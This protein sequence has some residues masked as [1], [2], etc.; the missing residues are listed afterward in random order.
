ML[1]FDKKNNY[2]K[3]IFNDLFRLFR[4]LF[5]LLLFFLVLTA[6]IY[7]FF[8]YQN[9]VKQQL[10]VSSITQN[11]I[12]ELINKLNSLVESQL[13]I[14]R[15]KTELDE[16]IFYLIN[17]GIFEDVKYYKIK[18]PE[19]N[20]LKNI[21]RKK[22]DKI[23]FVVRE[24][25]IVDGEIYGIEC[26]YD[27][28][29][30]SYLF[31]IMDNI[32]NFDYYLTYSQD[33]KIIFSDDFTAI[34]KTNNIRSQKTDYCGTY[35]NFENQF[36]IGITRKI[37]NSNLFF[38][39]EYNFKFFL[40]PII[41]KVVLALLAL[42]VIIGS[43]YIY[44]KNKFY[45]RVEKLKLLTERIS[46]FSEKN[47]IGA[48]DIEADDEIGNLIKAYND[49]IKQITVFTRRLKLK[50]QTAMAESFMIGL[51]H[52]INSPLR[53]ISLISENLKTQMPDNED[54]LTLVKQIQRINKTLGNMKR[55]QEQFDE[56]SIKGAYIMK[57]LDEIIRDFK[58]D[59]AI[60]IQNE[61]DSDIEVIGGED[62]LS[63]V[64][65]E[66]FRNSFHSMQNTS[67]FKMNIVICRKNEFDIK[68]LI[69]DTGI[70]IHK[71]N[72]SEIFEPFKSG[73]QS[74]GLGMYFCKQS[75]R[76]YQGNIEFI[77]K[78]GESVSNT[79]SV[80]LQLWD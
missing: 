31:G 67:V 44:L 45:N 74:T 50:T 69:T 62:I 65:S 49:M 35:K 19:K 6:V 12:R 4:N 59:I 79:V 26:E 15:T 23:F 17:N 34:G 29:D 27:F 80:C 54:V 9:F 5:I 7:I 40:A 78:E 57:T 63:L 21:I 8:T 58:F 70:G 46:A 10:L 24:N 38:S 33:N 48:L 11:Q 72:V 37:E 75:I 36:V 60:T 39:V 61:N 42:F 73:R 64:F 25:I 52:E 71:N 43:I 53:S 55:T 18:K 41:F 56:K 47:V 30:I 16:I 76:H 14:V 13:Y 32:Y 68:I 77:F 28:K 2:K 51:G 20:S 3:S 1:W 66:L 22:D